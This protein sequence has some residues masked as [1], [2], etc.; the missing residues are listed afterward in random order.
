ME[1]L[2]TGGAGYIGSHTVV[3]LLAAGQESPGPKAQSLTDLTNP[4][5]DWTALAKG[6]GVPACTAQTDEELSAALQRS[7]AE[8]GPS[9]VEAVVN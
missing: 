8:P 4:V 1:L 7:L 2:V 5:M 9:L 6:F 3:E